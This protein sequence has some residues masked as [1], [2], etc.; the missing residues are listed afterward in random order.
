M[1]PAVARAAFAAGENE[2][3][4]LYALQSLQAVE[5]LEKSHSAGAAVHY[6]NLVLGRVALIDGRADQAQEHLLAAGRTP[7]SPKLSTFGPSMTLASELL[8][9]G[10]SDT[11]LEYLELCRAFWSGGGER[12]DE[13]VQQIQEGSMPSF[14]ANLEF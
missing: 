11:V 12:I 2:R 5:Q 10:D 7:G 8:E 6:G 14:G 9:A 4:R 13:W 1:L 3:A